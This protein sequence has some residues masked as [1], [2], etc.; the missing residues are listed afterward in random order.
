MASIDPHSLP[1]VLLC[2][3]YRFSKMLQDGTRYEK[4]I[5]IR[6]FADP[7]YIYVHLDGRSRFITQLHYRHLRFLS[8]YTTYTLYVINFSFI[9][10]NILV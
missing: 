6:L 3:A 1:R 7:A 8:L 9:I 4:H 5:A 10:W 2:L